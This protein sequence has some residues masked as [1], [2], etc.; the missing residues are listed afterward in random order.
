M[1]YGDA[2][3]AVQERY[4]ARDYDGAAAA[5]P[6]EFIDATSLIGPMERIADRM[7]AFASSGVTTLTIQTYA[8]TLDERLRAV[9]TA[10]EALDH[11]GVGE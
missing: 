4:L 10:A 9:R 2:A 8:P 1:G 6:F 7:Q 5:I 11:S 3:A